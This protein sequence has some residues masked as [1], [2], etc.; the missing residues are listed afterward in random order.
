MTTL[1]VKAELN[2]LL[3]NL[4]GGRLTRYPPGP[5]IDLALGVGRDNHH[6]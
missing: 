5:K 3:Y 1:N 4:L 6:T 2:L